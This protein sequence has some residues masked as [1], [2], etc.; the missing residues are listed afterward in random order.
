VSWIRADEL[1]GSALHDL[2]RFHHGDS[3]RDVTN[4]GEIVRDEQARKTQPL[5]QI[6]EQIQNLRLHGDIESAHRF[7]ADQ[8]LG[9]QRQSPGDP[10]ALPLTSRQ[11]VGVP[12]SM[13]GVEPH[14]LQQ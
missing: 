2:A 11:H 6:R 14:H 10:D 9:F 7:I 8:K 5:P 12:I 3:I 1:S 13:I 4:H